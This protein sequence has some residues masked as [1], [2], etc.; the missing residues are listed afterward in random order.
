[1]R[2]RKVYKVYYWAFV[3]WFYT[4]TC[5]FLGGRTKLSL[6]LFQ[7]DCP[8]GF[9]DR[10]CMLH[11]NYAIYEWGLHFLCYTTGRRLPPSRGRG[12]SLHCSVGGRLPS[13]R[14]CSSRRMRPS[15]SLPSSC[16]I[17]SKYRITRILNLER[18][19]C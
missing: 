16:S 1:M 7:F 8:C 3:S 5:I 10:S 4:V 6:G 2:K 14:T 13:C 19:R 9:N 12:A 15:L 11:S 17:S 18:G